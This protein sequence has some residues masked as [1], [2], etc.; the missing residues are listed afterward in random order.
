METLLSYLESFRERVNAASTREELAV[1]LRE[2]IEVQEMV[3]AELARRAQ[4]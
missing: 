2:I 3:R 4:E 1:L